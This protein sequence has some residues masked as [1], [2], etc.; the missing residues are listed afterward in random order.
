M[1][2]QTNDTIA[3]IDSIRDMLNSVLDTEV[4]ATLKVGR[5]EVAP[6]AT[7]GEIA[8]I[9]AAVALGAWLAS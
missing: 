6:V 8:T 5:I 4:G 9:G 1:N 3:T 7:L 2:T